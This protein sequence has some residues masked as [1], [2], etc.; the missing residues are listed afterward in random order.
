MRLVNPNTV[1]KLVKGLLIFLTACTLSILIFIIYYLLLK[2]LPV[3]RPEMFTGGAVDMGRSGGILPFVLSTVFLT[4]V[5][6]G[7]AAWR[8][9]PSRQSFLILAYSFSTL[10]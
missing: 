2:G 8:L 5:A 10:V 9:L 6:A 1:Q 7:F 3:F 4:A